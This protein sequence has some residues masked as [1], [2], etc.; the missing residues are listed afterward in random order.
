MKSILSILILLFGG[1][2]VTN[3]QSKL[4]ATS[5]YHHDSTGFFLN[6][7]TGNFYKAANTT[8]ATQLYGDGLVNSTADSNLAYNNNAGTIYLASKS[9][10]TYNAN[11][12]QRTKYLG[13]LYDNLGVNTYTYQ[14]DYYYNGLQLDSSIGIYTNVIP[15][16]TYK[17][18]NT[19]Y[20][21][22]G[23]NQMDTTWIVYFTNL[24]VYSSSVKQVNTYNGNNVV[25][26]LEYESTDSVTYVPD[27]RYNYYYNVNNVTDSVVY[28]QWVAPSWFKVA[29]NEFTYNANNLKIR[30]EYFSFNNATQTYSKSARDQYLRSNNTEIDT[31][32]SQLW[33]QGTA[34]YDTTVKTGYK[35]Q[36]GVLLRAYGFTKNVNNMWQPNPYDGI[37]NFYYDV[38]P[39]NIKESKLEKADVSIFPNPAEHVL[40][41]KKDY[42]GSK[43]YISTLDG[44]YVQSGLIDAKNQVQVDLLATGV[45]IILVQDR[46][47]IAQAKFIKL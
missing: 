12:T 42:M 8:S 10:N 13:Y 6:D 3:A 31:A 22:N 23:H 15:N 20:H 36:G 38:V 41:F 19:F 24:G 45:Y 28:F 7:S 17:Y 11:Y 37:R 46:A 47:G 4:I 43:Y 14:T 30:K 2:L 44:K 29:K 34:M 39:N 35:Y 33:N 40:Q 21:Y 9:V 27:S 16:N 5:T 25:E 18:Y 32:Y 26:I 1:F